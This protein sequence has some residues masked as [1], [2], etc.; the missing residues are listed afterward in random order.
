MSVF[1]FQFAAEVLRSN[2][3]LL[4]NHS[5]SAIIQIRCQDWC[6][7]RIQ[8]MCIR[9]LPLVR[10]PFIPEKTTFTFTGKSATCVTNEDSVNKRR[11]N[12]AGVRGWTGSLSNLNPSHWS[13]G[14]PQRYN[15][16]HI[17]QVTQSIIP[18]LSMNLLPMTSY[19]HF[20]FPF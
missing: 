9:P 19:H 3:L 14:S 1:V 13:T 11:M 4:R 5:F 18:I 7:I 10:K 12:K 2:L 17:S 16:S 15:L 6:S 20:L 8:C